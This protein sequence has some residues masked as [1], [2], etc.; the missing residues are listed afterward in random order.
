[1]AN[2]FHTNQIDCLPF[3][4]FIEKYPWIANKK[5]YQVFLEIG[6][7]CVKCNLLGTHWVWW[8]EEK[9]QEPKEHWDLAGYND[10]GH[11]VM[12]TIDHIMPR[13]KGG[14][15][16]TSNYQPMC[17]F[18]NQKKADKIPEHLI[19]KVNHVRTNTKLS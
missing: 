13:S 8:K 12:I 1:M 15:N 16:D 10:Q 14:A 18:C 5:R 4:E 19:K 17:S 3:L 9:G 7:N 11:L 2:P 6:F